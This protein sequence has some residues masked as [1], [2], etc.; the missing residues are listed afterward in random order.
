MLLE[1]GVQD[2]RCSVVP[3]RGRRDSQRCLLPSFHF[4]FGVL[5]GS[6]CS[7][8]LWHSL[9]FDVFDSPS[10]LLQDSRSVCEREDRAEEGKGGNIES[11]SWKR[12]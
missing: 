12:M 3:V 9:S 10:F 8:L 11:G 7:S 2:S 4:L 1:S 5:E 6:A